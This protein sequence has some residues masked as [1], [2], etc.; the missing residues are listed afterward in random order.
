M[1]AER[2]ALGGLLR[3]KTCADRKAAA[4]TLG[5]RRDVG[6]D[7]RLLDCKK[8]AGPADAGLHLVENQQ[9]SVAI[10]EVPH[11]S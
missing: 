6:R 8:A 4:E 5:E 2:H 10:A 11:S 7:A 9:Q 3:R 1:R